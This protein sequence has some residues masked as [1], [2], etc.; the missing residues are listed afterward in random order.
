MLSPVKLISKKK[1]IELEIGILGILFELFPIVSFSCKLK[2][3]L[4]ILLEKAVAPH[5]STLAWETP[6]TEEP[7]RL[8][9]MGSLRVRHD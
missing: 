2:H 8:Q 7:D 4:Y 3:F 1:L 6:W 9:S 5:S